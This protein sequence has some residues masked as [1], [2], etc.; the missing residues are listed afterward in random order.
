MAKRQERT[1]L[2]RAMF[3]A[4]TAVIGCSS[5][6]QAQ[7]EPPSRQPAAGQSST[8]P[9][10]ADADPSDIVVT[11]QRR[12]ER[13]VDVPIS[14]SLL[15]AETIRERRVEQLQDISVGTP[16]ADIKVHFPGGAPVVTIRGIGLDDYNIINNPSAGVYI[17]EIPLSTLNMLTGEYYD[18]QRIEVLKG[19]QGTLYGRSATAGAI[20]IVSAR[21]RDR[22]ESAVTVGYGNYSALTGEAMINVPVSPALALRFS[23]KTIQQYQ[24]YWTNLLTSG[25]KHNL[26]ERH[27]W[28]GRA[29]ALWQPTAAIEWLIKAE[30]QRGR[31]QMGQGQG[32]GRFFCEFDPENPGDV[33][34]G[35][36]NGPFLNGKFPGKNDQWALTSRLSGDLGWSEVIAV[37]GYRELDLD[38]PN[39][40]DAT[41][42][43]GY[44]PRRVQFANQF[45]QEVRM[46]GELPIAD[47]LVGVFYSWDHT[48]EVGTFDATGIGLRFFNQPL[49][50]L[51]Q[52][53]QVSKSAAGFANATWK[54]TDQLRFT[55]GLRYTWERKRFEG[56]SDWNPNLGPFG[57]AI[58]KVPYRDTSLSWLA[59]AEY[60]PSTRMLFY[61]SAA[62]A[63]KS[64]GIFGGSI[65]NRSQLRSYDPE[66]LT[67]YEVGAKFAPRT[68]AVNAAAFYYDV[69][70]L[71]A[72][73][74]VPT[75][76][77]ATIDSIP[78]SRMYGL[79]LDG[80]WRPVSGLSLLANIGYTHT[81]LGSFRG[82]AGVIPA[83]NRAPNSP[84]ITA[85]GTARYEFPLSSALG[86]SAQMSGKYAGSMFR[87]A[88]NNPRLHVPDHFEID[89]RIALFNSNQTW[90]VA[91]WVKNLTKEID[92]QS[93]VDANSLGVINFSYTAPR[94]YGITASRKF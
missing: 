26:G 79:E 54:L 82:A 93:V 46:Q 69:E 63:S 40:G 76:V 27:I 8:E 64:G 53:D 12:E 80:N 88:T 58:G 11:A 52:S 28:N 60:K 72:I 65:T 2:L 68:L 85:G 35:R 24:G 91:G 50:L 73:S 22:F 17:D 89:G 29:Q 92:L 32:C 4:S 31:I 1:A 13:L 56:G 21:P 62:K 49:S 30:G 86:A 16:N 94:T 43:T 78:K 48:G 25:G 75:V 5:G 67:S 41:S 18:L 39:D 87:D 74:R 70:N 66:R 3:W 38:F 15:S 57:D 42:V 71:Q 37:T 20:N 36:W 14:V 9:K 61:A 90:E 44:H 33:Y 81:R 6:A 77:G 45:T 34:V 59:R 7:D 19:P 47:W 23:G 10:P 83:G 55:T 84:K 51:Y